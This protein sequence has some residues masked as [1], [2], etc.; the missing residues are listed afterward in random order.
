MVKLVKI[1]SNTGTVNKRFKTDFYQF[2]SKSDFLGQ[3]GGVAVQ[4]RICPITSKF[5]TVL[6]YIKSWNI[7]HLQV[8][9]STLTLFRHPYYEQSELK[10]CATVPLYFIVYY[11]D[12]LQI[13]IRKRLLKQ[14]AFECLEDGGFPN[15]FE[16]FFQSWV[17]LGADWILA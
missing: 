2:F 8:P 9:T 5:F 6:L 12:L 14:K 1:A 11:T 3:K 10:N 7:S 13:L 16:F 17:I 15:L 4:I